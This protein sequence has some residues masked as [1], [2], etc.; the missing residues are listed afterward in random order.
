MKPLIAS[1]AVI[2]VLPSGSALHCRL[3]VRGADPGRDS[4]AK[5]YVCAVAPM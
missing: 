3:R 4:G 5:W 1:G 2:G